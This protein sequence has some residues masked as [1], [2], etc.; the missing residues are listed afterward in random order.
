MLIISADG[1]A[2]R[3]EEAHDD[4]ILWETFEEFFDQGPPLLKL[5]KRCTM[6]PHCFSISKLPDFRNKILF[7]ALS[8]LNPG[9]RPRV[10]HGCNPQRQI[11]KPQ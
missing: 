5:T 3:A 6:E 2:R 4:L 7:P 1:I 11:I 8:A 9:L 10:K